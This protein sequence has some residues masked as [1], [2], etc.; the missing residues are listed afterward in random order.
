MLGEPLGE[1]DDERA[2]LARP[3]ACRPWRWR[4][5]RRSSSSYQAG[6]SRAR[7]GRWRRTTSPGAVAR[8][9]QRREGGGGEVA[10][11]P[12]GAH[13]RRLGG[14]VLGHGREQPGLG[15]QLGPH[16][17]GQHRRGHRPPAL[18]GQRGRAEQLGQP[19][20]GEERDRGQAHARCRRPARASPRTAAAATATPTWFDGTTTVTGAS[21]SPALP[22]ATASRRAQG[23]L[24]PVR[25]PHHAQR[26]GARLGG[27]CDSDGGA[28]RTGP[29]RR[30][31][32]GGQPMR[33]RR[34][35]LN[36]PSVA[37]SLPPRL[38]AIPPGCDSLPGRQLGA[39]V[40]ARP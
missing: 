23:R 7:V 10:Q 20:G 8:P 13:E 32:A 29:H 22:S 35:L 6:S 39:A 26:H 27:R 14:R 24:R 1:V 9:G 38:N 4:R 17:R 2:E 31:P 3:R 33:S 16:R 36:V 11:L 30:K 25:G 40:P 21:G 18:P 15:G 19:V 5:A 28:R 12:V 37:Y 34:P